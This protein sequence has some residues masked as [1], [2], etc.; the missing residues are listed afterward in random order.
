MQNAPKNKNSKGSFVSQEV[1]AE[2]R[3]ALAIISGFAQIM[4]LKAKPDMIPDTRRQLEEII[5]QVDR[6]NRLLPK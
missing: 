3:N 1:L 2:T 6:I 4:I 5:N